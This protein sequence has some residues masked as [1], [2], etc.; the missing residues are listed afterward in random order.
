MVVGVAA[1]HEPDPVLSAAIRLA[2]RTGAALHVVHACEVSRAL[3]DGLQARLEGMV[4]GLT[5]RGRVFCE[6][7]EGD[8][9]RVLADAA[10]RVNADLVVVGPTRRG[11]LGRALLG[12]TAQRVLHSVRRPVL[13]LKPPLC[14]P[15][16]RVLLTTDLSEFSEVVHEAAMDLL[17]GFFTGGAPEL[18]ALLVARDGRAFP[19]SHPDG[20]GDAGA[21]SALGRFLEALRPRGRPLEGAVR[22]GDPSREI[23]AEAEAW[24]ADL[25][26]LGTHG[27]TGAARVL[28]GSVAE[29]ALRS[30]PCSVLV[31]P[32][33]AV[34]SERASLPAIEARAAGMA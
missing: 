11:V 30:T 17:D 27:R 16:G 6:V 23:A 28:L 25:V 4:R 3:P 12:T 24:G 33:G 29:D 21:A 15:P 20:H 2:A 14:A 34:A 26:V 31:I 22:V 8:P 9:D 19:A 18:R 5:D 10:D 1:L 32:A 13:V 7:V